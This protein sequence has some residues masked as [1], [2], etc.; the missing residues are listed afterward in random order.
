MCGI[1]HH[2]Y[3]IYCHNDISHTHTHLALLHPGHTQT[4]STSSSSSSSTRLFTLAVYFICIGKKTAAS[5]F[6]TWKK[7]QLEFKGLFIISFLLGC[8]LIQKW[9]A[10]PCVFTLIPKA[11]PH[12]S[13]LQIFLNSL[14]LVYSSGFVLVQ[15]RAIVL[16]TRCS[17]FYY[18]YYF[19]SILPNSNQTSG[20]PK[21]LRMW[22]K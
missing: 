6:Q 19:H 21:F 10:W 18:C 11:P 1:I 8:H 20:K 9:K 14:E 12:C 13:F 17:F 16:F 7:L 15:V 3:N 2:N 22:S 4:L 5:T